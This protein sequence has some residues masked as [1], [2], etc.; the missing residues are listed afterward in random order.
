METKSCNSCGAPVEI[1]NRFSKV[2]VCNYCGCH[3]KIEGNTLGLAGE[4]P[5]LAEYPSIF[6]VG[7]TGKILDKPMRVL[8]RMRYKYDGGHYDEW[9][10]ELDGENAW[11]T[12]DE[13]TYA[14]FSNMEE[15][16]DVSELESLRAGQNF[17]LGDERVMIKEK[18]IA[19][20]DGGEG[21][22]FFYIEPGTEVTYIDAIA[23]GKKIS[24][25]YTDEEVELFS[26]RALLKRDIVIDS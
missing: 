19:V 15:M 9:F 14:L 11:L 23:Q 13:G 25:E 3:L 2:L 22:L 18:G 20:I 21:E 26:G 6:S 4:F 10:I 5:K 1:V 12:E 24:V 7:A 17:L 8:G 16:V